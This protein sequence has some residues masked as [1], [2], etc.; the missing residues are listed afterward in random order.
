MQHKAA[1]NVN[2]HSGAYTYPRKKLYAEPVAPHRKSST[3]MKSFGHRS[4][5]EILVLYCR[6]L[7]DT[8]YNI[9]QY[10]QDC[11]LAYLHA[12]IHRTWFY[13]NGKA[14][15]YSKD[16]ENDKQQFVFRSTE[17]GIK[18]PHPTNSH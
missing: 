12:A 11:N 13:Q 1:S 6:D 18:P 5:L 17:R 2:S 7:N 9:K 14:I 15:G 8:I 10:T 3:S 16:G 4:V